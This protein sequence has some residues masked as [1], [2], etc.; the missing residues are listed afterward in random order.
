M[1]QIAP[2]LPL[3]VFEA[4]MSILLGF[5]M[6]PKGAELLYSNRIFEVLGQCQ[7]MKAQIQDPSTTEINLESSMELSSRYQR[8]IMPTLELIV[9][10]LMTFGAKNDIVLNK[11][12]MF[13]CSCCVSTRIE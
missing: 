5:A 7:F 4:K 1:C 8:L 6:N 2:L 11:V 10:I 13:C 9:A 12:W 3:Y